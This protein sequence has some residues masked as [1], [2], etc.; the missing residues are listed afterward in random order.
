MPVDTK[1]LSKQTPTKTSANSHALLLLRHPLVL[2]LGLPLGVIAIA[3]PWLLGQHTAPSTTSS[4]PAQEITSPTLPSSPP[5]PLLSSS[6]MG[7]VSP[8][9]SVA[10]PSLLSGSPSSTQFPLPPTQKVASAAQSGSQPLTPSAPS[11]AKAGKVAAAKSDLS[12]RAAAAEAALPL[13][14]R[15]PAAVPPS[16]GPA[17]EIRVAIARN[18]AVVSVSS[19]TPA[20]IVDDNGK[21]WGTLNTS[22]AVSAQRSSSG[23]SVGGIQMPPAAWLQ[24]KSGGFVFL[25]GRWYRGRVRL[26]ADTGGVLAVNYVDL[27]QY[28]PSVVGAEVYPHWPMDALK[29]Q[30]I[31]ARSY[32]LAH[33]FQPASRFFDLGNDQRWQVYQG[34]EKEW[35]TSHQAV[36]ATRGMVLSY[37]GSLVLSMYAADDGI[38][39]DVF[40]GRGMSQTGAYQMATKGYNF[41]QI[42]GAYYP[43]AGLSQVQVR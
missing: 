33:A 26:I 25:D 18:V 7:L 4:T 12:S 42:L 38:V 31:A 10:S 41:L 13:P 27:E 21:V 24:P 16:K 8:S 6:P 1:I 39:R 11:Q 29:A 37:K 5:L 3:L 22:Q 17:P 14:K 40:G 43:G 32:A 28:L 15:A 9:P 19:S 2:R 35:N 36:N 20:A 23:L 34:V 30:A